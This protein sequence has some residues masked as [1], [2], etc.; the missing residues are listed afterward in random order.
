[1]RNGLPDPKKYPR[2]VYV[3][4]SYYK[5]LFVEAE[6]KDL[7]GAIG[8]CDPARQFIKIRK[9]MSP[10]ETLATFIHEMA[11]ALEFEYNIPIKH[12]AV[13]KLEKAVFNLLLD[14]FL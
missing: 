11:H 14:N 6:D 4:D 12:K 13:Y 1:M 7:D 3:R 5:I 9:G 2:R 10:R 8:I